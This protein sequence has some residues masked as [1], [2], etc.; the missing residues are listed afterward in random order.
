MLFPGLSPAEDPQK[1]HSHVSAKGVSVVILRTMQ[2]PDSAL[3]SI[4][5]Q[6]L[7]SKPHLK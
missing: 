7:Q 3:Q 6:I 4:P 5:S 1:G 2:K